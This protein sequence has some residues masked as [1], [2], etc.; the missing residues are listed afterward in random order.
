ML[1][2]HALLAVR[3]RFQ[4]IKVDTT[5]AAQ[6]LMSRSRA[7]AGAQN[8]TTRRLARLSRG[9]VAVAERTRAE[10]QFVARDTEDGLQGRK[11]AAPKAD[12]ALEIG[13]YTD[14][15]HLVAPVEPFKSAS[16]EKTSRESFSIKGRTEAY[17]TSQRQSQG[18][19]CSRDERFR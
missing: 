15:R 10:A 5:A 18:S 16:R 4:T 19:S 8:M 11:A 17:L 14:C 7:R 1:L 9:P 13:P 3:V 2:D 6:I 12:V